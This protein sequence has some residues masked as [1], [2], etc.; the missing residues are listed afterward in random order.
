MAAV[1]YAR[2]STREQN[3]DGQTDAL[4]AAGCKKIFIEH[5]SGVLASI[6]HEA[7]SLV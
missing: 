6:F 1:G 3:L 5:A 4:E 7:V 2:V